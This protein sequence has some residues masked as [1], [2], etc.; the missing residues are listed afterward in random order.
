MNDLMGHRAFVN[1]WYKADAQE[2]QDTS[3]SSGSEINEEE[4]LEL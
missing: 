2:N 1:P 4:G 3:E